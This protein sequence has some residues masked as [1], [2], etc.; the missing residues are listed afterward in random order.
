MINTNN[1]NTNN[2]ALGV[3]TFHV[4]NDDKELHEKNEKAKR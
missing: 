3:S 4:A 2:V 1:S